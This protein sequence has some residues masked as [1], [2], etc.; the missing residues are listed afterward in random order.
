MSERDGQLPP[1]EWV[2]NDFNVGDRI[3]VDTLGACTIIAKRERDHHDFEL[4]VDWDDDH[5]QQIVW[6]NLQ[7]IG[8][9]ALEDTE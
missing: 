1:G 9:L 5:W 2:P 7:W 3:T 8:L 6:P 4:T